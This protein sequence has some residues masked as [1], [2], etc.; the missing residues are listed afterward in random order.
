[1]DSTSG[2]VVVK[3]GLSI[4]TLHVGGG[5]QVL[6]G[7]T[8]QGLDP[9]IPSPADVGVVVEGRKGIASVYQDE[10]SSEGS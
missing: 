2:A 5:G 4:A 8:W 3:D 7:R 10:R 6:K 1:M 9:S